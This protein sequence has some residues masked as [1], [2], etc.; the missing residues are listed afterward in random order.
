MAKALYASGTPL[1][2][3]PCVLRAFRGGWSRAEARQ[4]GSRMPALPELRLRGR[5][6]VALA[7]SPAGEPAVCDRTR[8]C[9]WLPSTVRQELQG[10]PSEAKAR[11]Y[12][13][14]AEQPWPC[15]R[16]RR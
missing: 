14:G 9:T 11:A 2:P 7:S 6:W 4:V 5:V 12:V 8:D 3:R 16:R 10:F 13:A 15:T 1:S